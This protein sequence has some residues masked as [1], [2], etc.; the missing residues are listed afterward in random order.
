MSR[1][2]ELYLR[3][4]LEA[5]QRIER[6]IAEVDKDSFKA[7][8]MRV[9]GVLFNLMTVGEAAKNIPDEVREHYPDVRWRDISRFRDR[10]V[11]HY[12][13][14]DLDIVWEIATVHLA[15]LKEFAEQL[16]RDTDDS[17]LEDEDEN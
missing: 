2:Y 14:L 4:I 8:D 12:F 16:L 3:D 10:V 7:D 6:Y 1:N 9:D 17:K 5:A 13:G 15:P 11:H